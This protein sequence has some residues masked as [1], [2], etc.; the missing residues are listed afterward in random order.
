MTPSPKPIHQASQG[1]LSNIASTRRNTIRREK[2]LG[3][4]SLLLLVL[5]TLRLAT[6]C[7]GIARPEG[8][9]G[10][11]LAGD[12]LVASIGRGEMA[13]VD[14]ED[15]G[16]RVV[17][18]FPLKGQ[19]HPSGSK[20][21]PVA[22]Y[23]TPQVAAET[24]FFGAYDG[25]LYALDLATG[26]I[27]WQAETGGPIVGSAVVQDGVVYV[28]SDDGKL[29]AFDA[30]TGSLRWLFKSGDSIWSIPLAADGVI[31]VAPMDKKVY[32]LDAASG[33][34]KWRF[35]ADGGLASTPVLADGTLLV[36]GIDR[37]LYALDAASGA[38]KWHFKADNWFWTRPLV[39]GD[40]VYAG[41]L[42]GKVYALALNDGSPKWEKPFDTGAPVRAAPL[43]LDDV[44]LVANRKGKLF[45]L[46]PETGQAIW[47]PTEL[48]RTVLADPL[49]QGDMAY[50]S[51]QG[52]KL[53]T[54]NKDGSTA[55]LVLTEL[56]G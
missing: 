49:A 52:G 47:G 40:S 8:W 51:V 5:A 20:I 42:D 44:L 43:L 46:D 3:S 31:Y 35:Q 15:S 38:E 45:G 56:G 28:G 6:A 30:E 22:I 13:A 41:C 1:E 4:L 48:L 37:R 18:R 24:V 19:K 16:G 26:D 25:W 23:S 33:A 39:L 34:E 36:G 17:W 10:P 12:R 53:F 54:V 7:A 32:A 2:L 21:L 55:L 27:R 9:A 29:Y 14:I 50:V 11:T